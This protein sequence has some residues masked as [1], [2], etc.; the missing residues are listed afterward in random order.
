MENYYDYFKEL[1][2][3]STISFIDEDG[4]PLDVCIQ[5][6]GFLLDDHKDVKVI[7]RHNL[8]ADRL[9]N[10]YD[11]KMLSGI[12]VLARNWDM[13]KESFYHFACNESDD[14]RWEDEGFRKHMYN[15]Y[16]NVDRPITD[17]L[18]NLDND[19]RKTLFRYIDEYLMSG[20]AHYYVDSGIRFK[21]MIAK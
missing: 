17:Q 18:Y 15:Q 4:N 3:K 21:K 13:Y 6:G 16:I 10:M 14:N 5:E 9:V 8:P 2:E 19:N 20:D 1:P 11:L 12:A 7:L